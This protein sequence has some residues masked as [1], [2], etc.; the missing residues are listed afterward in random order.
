MKYYVYGTKTSG[1]TG[2]HHSEETK[3]KIGAA[4]SIAL[5]GKTL[6]NETKRKISKSVS[7]AKMG[8]S[9]P[10]KGYTPSIE[11]RQKMSISA[12]KYW[13]IKKGTINE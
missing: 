1:M 9:H 13:A 12:K 11:T 5:K 8:K 3:R 6:S 7:L 2:K 10:H 4:N